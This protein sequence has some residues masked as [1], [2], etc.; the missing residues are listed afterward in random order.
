METKPTKNLQFSGRDKS[1]LRGCQKLSYGENGEA[2][3]VHHWFEQLRPI[4]NSFCR[5]SFFVQLAGKN[6]MKPE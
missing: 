5:R 6:Q 1:E 4:R 3:D 2:V